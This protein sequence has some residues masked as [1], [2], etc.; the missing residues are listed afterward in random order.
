MSMG[1]HRC[2]VSDHLNNLNPQ[3]EG[4]EKLSHVLSF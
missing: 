3:S 4:L 1:D 2:L